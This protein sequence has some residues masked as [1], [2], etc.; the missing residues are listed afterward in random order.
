MT[1]T[2]FARPGLIRNGVY[3]HLKLEILSGKLP[4]G[5]RLAE[6]ALAE[7]LG[8]SRTPVREAVQR[9]AQDGLVEVAP[10][11]GA[12]VRGV[13]T[14][15]VEEVYTVREVLDGLAARLAATKR[16][17]HDLE[18]MRAALGRLEA[19]PSHDYAAQIQADLD[20]HGAIAN[21]SGNSALETTL[22]GLSESVARVKLLTKKYNQAPA[23]KAAHLEL[24]RAIEAGD[25]V[26]AERAARMHVGDFRTII[27]TELKPILGGA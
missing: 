14:R 15:E 21:A 22:R 26:R 8:V 19:A 23:T 24:L 2:G 4:S 3:D 18:A 25:G 16:T 10:N 27:L 7:R 13:S 17:E 11:R 1:A 6:I 5:S 20:F 12:R 9:L